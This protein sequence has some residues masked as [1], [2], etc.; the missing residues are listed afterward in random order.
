MHSENNQKTR[1]LRSSNRSFVESGC[2]N[3]IAPAELH[4]NELTVLYCPSTW[5]CSTWNSTFLDPSLVTM[6]VA[7]KLVQLN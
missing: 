3:N 2:W 7:V 6:N 4:L 1:H 5:D